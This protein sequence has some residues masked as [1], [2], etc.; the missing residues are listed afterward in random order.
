[1]TEKIRIVRIITYVGDRDWV[2]DTVRKSIHG[3]KEVRDGN[4]IYAATIG[5]F[6][7]RFDV[8]PGP[9]MAY[10]EGIGLAFAG[11]GWKP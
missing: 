7:E 2:E 5:V 1:M 9:K 4:Y 10:D 3:H 11:Y 8:P 6:P